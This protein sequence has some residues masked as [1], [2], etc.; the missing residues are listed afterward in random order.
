M[1]ASLQRMCAAR[2]HG[3]ARSAPPCAG[4]TGSPWAAHPNGGRC[5]PR[6]LPERNGGSTAGRSLRRALEPPVVPCHHPRDPGEGRGWSLPYPQVCTL[7]PAG[8]Q[9]CGGPKA[10]W[11]GVGPGP[12]GRGGQQVCKSSAPA[13]RWRSAPRHSCQWIQG[14]PP[15]LRILGWVGQEEAHGLLPPIARHTLGLG[16]ELH[17]SRTGRTSCRHS[18]GCHP[19]PSR[20][21]HPHLVPT[22]PLPAPRVVC[23]RLSA[24]G[25][26]VQRVL[27]S[28][29]NATALKW[30]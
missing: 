9:G 24:G 23:S 13:S 15:G 21:H 6:T 1:P 8:G 20:Q 3:D 27:G 22:C 10:W 29:G 25:G 14:S 28:A 11:V 4:R 2:G 30:E 16:V 17:S 18:P 19:G 12:G 7:A 5:P 26:G